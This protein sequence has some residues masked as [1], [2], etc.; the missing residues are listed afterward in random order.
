MIAFEALD[1]GIVDQ[2][3]PDDKLEETAIQFAQDLTRKSIR[4]LAGIKKL[5]NY[6]IK[7]LQDYLDFESFEMLKTIG[8]W[9]HQKQ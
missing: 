8:T 5:I 6:N 3:V 2:V 9:N 7:D 1:M 4:S